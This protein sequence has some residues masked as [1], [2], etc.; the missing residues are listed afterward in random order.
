MNGSVAGASSSV[1]ILV[2]LTGRWAPR[3]YPACELSQRKEGESNSQGSYARTGSSRV[4]SPVGLSF[5]ISG[6]RAPV[7]APT[8]GRRNELPTCVRAVVPPAG[9]AP[10]TSWLR[11][12]CS[13]I[14]LWRQSCE[15]QPFDG[16][17]LS[18]CRTPRPRR[19][20]LLDGGKSRSRTWL[21]CRH[22]TAAALRQRVL[23]SIWLAP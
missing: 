18:P 6:A 12:T 3:P 5:Q 13:S 10:A 1:G 9:L 2:S 23:V 4:P 8:V 22:T 20:A 11:A 21:A 17:D 14:E 19:A 16:V 7:I 15:A